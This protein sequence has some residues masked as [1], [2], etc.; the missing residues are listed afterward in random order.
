MWKRNWYLVE[1]EVVE[2]G[3]QIVRRF[4]VH[5]PKDLC[6]DLLAHVVVP[7]RLEGAVAQGDREVVT[8]LRCQCENSCVFVGTP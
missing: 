8:K 4:K 3:E 1:V 7:A 5:L 2:E 6:R